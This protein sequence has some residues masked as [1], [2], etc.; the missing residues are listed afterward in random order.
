MADYRKAK[1]TS[2]YKNVPID[3]LYWYSKELV[4]C[5][6]PITLDWI[7]DGSSKTQ[8]ILEYQKDRIDNSYWKNKG[9]VSGFFQRL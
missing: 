6:L 3:D 9:L 4:S 2:E 7:A 1:M 5:Y 8:L